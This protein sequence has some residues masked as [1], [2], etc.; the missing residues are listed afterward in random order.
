MLGL[1]INSLAIP[2]YEIISRL[3]KLILANSTNAA[4]AIA[5]D[6]ALEDMGDGFRA[7]YN[8]ASRA[9]AATAPV[10][11]L[12]VGPRS[13]TRRVHTRTRSRSLSPARRRDN[14]AY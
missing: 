8:E 11:V 13:P 12:P 5:L 6:S 1:D 9:M 10:P 14:R 7:G 3:E 2:D 4:T